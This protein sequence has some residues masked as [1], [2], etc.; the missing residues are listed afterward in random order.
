MIGDWSNHLNVELFLI[1]CESWFE[2]GKI[3]TIEVGLEMDALSECWHL[4]T[5][6]VYSSLNFARTVTEVEHTGVVLSLAI[7]QSGND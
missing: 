3:I 4:A 6:E 7:L 5:C 1:I 2:H